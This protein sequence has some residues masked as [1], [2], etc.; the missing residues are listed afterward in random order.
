M[1]G[2]TSSGPS[3]HHSGRMSAAFATLA[4]ILTPWFDSPLRRRCEGFANLVAY[5]DRMMVRFFPDFAWTAA[6]PPQMA[7]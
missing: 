1:T 5:V 3:P 4:Q 6:V 2:S 7:A